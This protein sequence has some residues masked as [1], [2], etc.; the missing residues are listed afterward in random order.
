MSLGSVLGSTRS[1]WLAGLYSLIIS[2]KIASHYCT[3]DYMCI[4]SD[5]RPQAMS[6]PCAH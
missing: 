5:I 1:E 2:F 4:P 6:I 3:K